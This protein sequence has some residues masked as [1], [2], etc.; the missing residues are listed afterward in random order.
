MTLHYEIDRTC[1]LPHDFLRKLYSEHFP[2]L[3][4]GTYVEVGAYDGVSYGHT[5]AL[6]RLGWRGLCVE[7][8]PEHAA[9]CD[10]N[11]KPYNV[12]VEVCAAGA[13]EGMTT[14]FVS[15]DCAGACSSTK[16]TD[17][18]R[19]H[20]L[21][22]AHGVL[23][24]VWKLDTILRRNNISPF[25][26]VLTIDVEEAELDVLAGF[27]LKY[28]MPKVAIIETHECMADPAFNWKAGPVADIFIPAGYRKVFA[29]IINTVFV[30]ASDAGTA[31]ASD[32]GT[33]QASDAGTAQASDGPPRIPSE[34]PA[35]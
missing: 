4:T 8:H 12:T 15:E 23:T 3:T 21:D 20:K 16:L 7:A 24:P 6:A 10:A 27:D 32:A 18:S 35:P 25:F 22:E 5:S 31:Q 34:S 28:W 13:T 29:D 30:R 33:A 17:A 26:E 14:L 9:R 19:S 11:L 1:Q 2:D